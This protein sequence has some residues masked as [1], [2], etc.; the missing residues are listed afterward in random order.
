MGRQGSL[1]QSLRV[2]LLLIIPLLLVC[3]AA[4][5]AYRLTFQNGTSVEVQAYEDL[6][7]AI[8]YPRLGGVVVVPKSSVST[9]EE[10]VH[11]PPPTVLPTA[12]AGSRPG[13][14]EAQSGDR[15]S[16]AVP[17]LPSF[18][19]PPIQIPSLQWQRV[20]NTAIDP[21]VIR[22][23]TGVALVAALGGIVAFF[24]S[25]TW[26]GSSEW[27]E[28]GA[29]YRR[30]ARREGGRP[31][32]IV[33][34]GIY[35]V[36]FGLLMLSVGLAG[37]VVGQGVAD[38]PVFLIPPDSPIVLILVSLAALVF[39]T[40]VLATAYGMWSLQTWGWRLQIV[41][42]FTDILLNAHALLLNPPSAG[43]LFAV[44]GLFIDSAI[45]L[46]VSR[47]QLRDWYADQGWDSE[48]WGEPPTDH[49][50][51]TPSL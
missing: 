7:D 12:S 29:D 11:F 46:Y 20:G 25:N 4:E 16:G 15:S 30:A 14:P 27:V 10:A 1:K 49:G 24:M 23:L 31:L 22:I 43:S 50:P 47:S 13:A 6:G 26:T 18:T 44:A 45:L 40:I 34:V 19:V 17:T 41:V 32:G 21:R 36:F 28:S 38:L 42:C 37:V 8:R 39:G 33:L 9:I 2:L 5:A 35:D 51:H 48:E 3:S